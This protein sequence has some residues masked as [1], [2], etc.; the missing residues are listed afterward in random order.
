MSSQAGFEM[1]TFFKYKW[2]K[3]FFE[4]ADSN[5]GFYKW[6]IDRP[7]TNTDIHSIYHYNM[8]KTG[9]FYYFSIHNTG[10]LS[11]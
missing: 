1:F 5:R 2:L 10:L 9:N 6:D 11:C 3:N 7:E 8:C 4:F